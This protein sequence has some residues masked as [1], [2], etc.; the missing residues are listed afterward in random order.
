MKENFI[1]TNIK[2]REILDGRGIPTVEVDVV[3]NHNVFSRAQVP[4]GNSTGS[5]EAFE[6]RDGEK[7]YSGRGVK[8]AINN[9]NNI[10]APEIIG[11]DVTHQK[12]LDTLMIELDG[13]QNKSKLGANAILGVSLA[14][15]KATAS[16]L[17]IPLYRHFNN[18]AN[19]I[20]RASCRE[21]V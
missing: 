6:L 4:S 5:H 10:I 21:R 9:V 20:G 1:I 7:R 8:K 19:K 11:K 18:D 3:V 2:A 17:Q 13:T 12:E 14:I 16:S 15:F